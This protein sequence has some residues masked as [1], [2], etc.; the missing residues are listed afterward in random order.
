MPVLHGVAADIAKEQGVIELHLSLSFTHTVGVASA[1][2]VT[3]N[4]RPKID[5]QSDPRAELAIAF[6]EARCLL[7]EM[8]SADFASNDT[9]KSDME[10]GE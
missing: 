8:D 5:K 4:N 2:A 3:E 9:T 1:V 10:A 6:K 7:D